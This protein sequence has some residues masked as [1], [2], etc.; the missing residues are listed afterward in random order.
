MSNS[1]MNVSTSH[2]S[3]L[4]AKTL[5]T[6]RI[7]LTTS[8]SSWKREERVGKPNTNVN[9]TI[10]R[11]FAVLDRFTKEAK[12]REGNL[13]SPRQYI[14]SCLKYYTG[15]IITKSSQQKKRVKRHDQVCN[16]NNSNN[17][18]NRSKHVTAATI[19][20]INL[21]A[22]Q[23]NLKNKKNILMQYQST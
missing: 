11:P 14:K 17:N 20:D 2:G 18:N 23:R 10:L 4:N 6:K 12:K 16:N 22:I 5:C 9:G 7:N 3:V 21:F 13:V 15:N 1:A 8:L 19:Q